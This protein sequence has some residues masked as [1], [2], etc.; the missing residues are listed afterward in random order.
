MEIKPLDDVMRHFSWTF[1][2]YIVLLGVICLN[3]CKCI[4]S[5]KINFITVIDL[6]VSIFCWI[7]MLAGYMLLMALSDNDVPVWEV[8]YNRL[9]FISN[10]SLFIIIINI[11]IF[12]KI[13]LKKIK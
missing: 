1:F 2:S 7:A 6:L 10:L 11:I 8:W 3:F 4:Y 13:K 9:N 5:N 12:I